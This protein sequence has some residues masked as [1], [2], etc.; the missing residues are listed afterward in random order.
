MSPVPTFKQTINGRVLI[1]AAKTT[2]A[3]HFCDLRQEALRDHPSFFGSSYDAQENCT[4]EWAYRVLNIDPFDE[5]SFI[6][7]HNKILIGM[8]RIRRYTGKKIEHSATIGGVYTRPDWRGQRIIDGLFDA[9]FE[10][11][12]NQQIIIVKLAVVTTNQSAIQA[13]KRMGFQIYGTEPKV[14]FYNGF[15]FDEHMMSLELPT[16]N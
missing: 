15:Y 12:R 10:W 9:C 13:Y 11:A 5:C 16:I 6:A 7:E 8:A 1:R 3:P 14:I 4:L 2:D